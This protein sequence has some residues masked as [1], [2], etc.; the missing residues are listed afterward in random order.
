MKT[1]ELEERV[2]DFAVSIVNI[3]E[4]IKESYAGNQW[5]PTN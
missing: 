4:E 1:N 2:I 5:K 3:A